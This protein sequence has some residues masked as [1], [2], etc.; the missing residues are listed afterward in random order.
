[1]FNSLLV[2]LL[3]FSYSMR[4]P[5]IEHKPFD[6]EFSA[7]V[8]IENK[9]KTIESELKVLFEREVGLYGWGHDFI[10]KYHKTN[11]ILKSLLGVDWV[12]YRKFTS[13]ERQVNNFSVQT[14]DTGYKLNNWFKAGY[15]VVGEHFK[16]IDLLYYT[17]INVDW[18]TFEVRFN[19]RRFVNH[20]NLKTKIPISD[21]VYLQPLFRMIH[22]KDNKDKKEYWGK[23]EI[24]YKL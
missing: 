4:T 19:F 7:G 2:S 14:I 1:M 23:L 8:G 13:Y 21:H 18:L 17:E 20:L 12:Y 9:A 11:E 5:A 24:V 16:E 10:F 22:L 3:L 6:Y 15:S